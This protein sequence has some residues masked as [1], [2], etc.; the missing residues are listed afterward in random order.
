MK[1][2]K[3]AAQ[4]IKQ[5]IAKLYDIALSSAPDK[6]AE[7]EIITIYQDI[8]DDLCDYELACMADYEELYTRR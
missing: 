1:R 6:K 8:I 5:D 4:H 7:N 2:R 3:E